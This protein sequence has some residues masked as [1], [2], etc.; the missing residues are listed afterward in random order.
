MT[1]LSLFTG[2]LLIVSSIT[3]V[4]EEDDD[5]DDLDFDFSIHQKST[6]QDFPMQEINQDELSNAAIAG[7]LQATSNDISQKTGKPI[8]AEQDEEDDKRETSELKEEATGPDVD[9]ILKF[10]QNLPPP[11][12]YQQPIYNTPNGRTYESHNTTTIERF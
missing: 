1:K 11:P 8:F 4:A 5:F 9:D 12:Q 6:L 10:S 3:L 2:F 7:A